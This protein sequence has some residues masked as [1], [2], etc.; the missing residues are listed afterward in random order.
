M[1][2]KEPRY[3]YEKLKGRLLEK[4]LSFNR[5]SE[6]SGIARNRFPEWSRSLRV[7]SD[8]EIEKLA[9][10]EELGLCLEELQAWKII[11]KYGE[12]ALK[13]A[14]EVIKQRNPEKIER[15]RQAYSEWKQA[16]GC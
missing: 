13:K 1:E 10:V 12:D 16:N 3:F 15:S 6:L 2:E 11:N 14:I 4:G 9:S 5:L 7:P 8:A